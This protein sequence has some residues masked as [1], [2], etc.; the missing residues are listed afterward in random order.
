MTYSQTVMF[1]IQAGLR[2]SGASRKPFADSICGQPLVL[3]PRNRPSR[4]Y[5]RLSQMRTLR[6]RR[7]TDYPNCPRNVEELIYWKKE[8]NRSYETY[9]N[10][11]VPLMEANRGLRQRVDVVD[12]DFSY[13]AQ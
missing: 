13:Q 1:A 3:L 9:R 10:A 4:A 8:W 6:A 12:R 2:L 11:L 5:I 7:R